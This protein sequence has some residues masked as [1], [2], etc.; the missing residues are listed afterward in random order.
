MNITAI[1]MA[2]GYGRRMGRNKLLLKY[3]NKTFMEHILENI[4][5]CDF[6]SRVIVARDEGILGLAESLGFKAIE[7]EQAF[8]GQSE[9]IK[10]GINNSPKS[11][12]YMFF[13]ADQPLLDIETIEILM[14]TFNENKYSIIIPKFRERRGSPVIFASRFLKE[15]QE[16]QGDVG[17]KKVID[18]NKEA[19][20]FAEITREE[21]LFDIDTYED[22]CKLIN[23]K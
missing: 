21:V 16:L 10:L 15:L 12:G 18:N 17:G 19:V 8:K 3:K 4:R 9:S 6:Y 1:I 7:N 13:T 22:Y 23:L 2:S 5:K 11:D 14:K 20:V